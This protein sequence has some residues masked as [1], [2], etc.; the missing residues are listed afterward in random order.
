[1]ESLHKHFLKDL[2]EARCY[3]I[4]ENNYTDTGG[5]LGFTNSRTLQTDVLGVEGRNQLVRWR[6]YI[7]LPENSERC[8]FDKFVCVMV[9]KPGEVFILFWRANLVSVSVIGVVI[10]ICLNIWL[11]VVWKHVELGSVNQLVLVWR[12]VWRWVVE[13]F[14]KKFTKMLALSLSIFK[15]VL[16]YI[17]VNWIR[18]S[19][20]FQS[21]RRRT[22]DYMFKFNVVFCMNLDNFW[23]FDSISEGEDW[24]VRSCTHKM[25]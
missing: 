18:F 13:I 6:S 20:T 4:V 24:I 1:M 22:D 25:N 19:W 11:L 8:C 17:P 23:P 7:L 12:A 10:W 2:S 3:C 15:G 5:T 14:W 16:L 21:V 9:S